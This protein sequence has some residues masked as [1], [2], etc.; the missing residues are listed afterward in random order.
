VKLRFTSRADED[1]AA[2]SPAIRKVF[3]QQLEIPAN[4]SA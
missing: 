1:Y 2:L 3:A 4:Q